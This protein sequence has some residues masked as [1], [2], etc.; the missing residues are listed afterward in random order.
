MSTRKSMS[1]KS[2]SNKSRSNKSNKSRSNKSNK[3]KSPK[4]LELNR[5]DNLPIDLQEYIKEINIKRRQTRR[6]QINR[7]KR[8]RDFIYDKKGRSLVGGKNKTKGRKQKARKTRG[9][10]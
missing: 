6:A 2:K 9:R 5:F 8:R 4:D 1:N 10:K 7:S 3:S